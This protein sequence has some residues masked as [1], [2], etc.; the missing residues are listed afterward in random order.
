MGRESHYFGFFSA[1]GNNIFKVY[2]G[3]DE[4]RELLSDQVTRFKALQ[5]QLQK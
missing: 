1:Q 3:R 2:L 5:Q 4:K